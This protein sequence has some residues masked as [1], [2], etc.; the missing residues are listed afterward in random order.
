MLLTSEDHMVCVCVS[1][2]EHVS[3][4]RDRGEYTGIP[5]QWAAAASR[6]RS[7]SHLLNVGI[8]PSEKPRGPHV[9]RTWQI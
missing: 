8:H 9:E 4:R 2:G 7:G 5:A 3:E 6:C 1:A